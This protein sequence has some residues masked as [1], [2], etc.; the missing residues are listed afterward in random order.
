VPEVFVDQLDERLPFQG[1][2]QRTD[3][4]DNFMAV[5]FGW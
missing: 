1:G 2:G 4:G 5:N 3:K